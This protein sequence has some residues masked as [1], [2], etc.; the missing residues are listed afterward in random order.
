MSVMNGNFGT[1][2]NLLVSNDIC[3]TGL[4]VRKTREVF[5]ARFRLFLRI[6]KIPSRLAKSQAK[7]VETKSRRSKGC[8][9]LRMTRHSP[10][11]DCTFRDGNP[12]DFPGF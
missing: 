9:A 12:E 10:E 11:N 5:C 6:M 2:S 8:H 7:A 4:S 1:Q 3:L